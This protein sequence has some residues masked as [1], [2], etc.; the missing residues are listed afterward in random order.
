MRKWGLV[1]LLILSVFFVGCLSPKLSIL[2]DPIEIE[3]GQE[4]LELGLKV[5]PS[6]F[7]RKYHLDTITISIIENIEGGEEFLAPRTIVVNRYFLVAPI[8]AIPVPLDPISLGDF[9]NLEGELYEQLRGREFLLKVVLDGTK[10]STA[11]AT[12]T[13]K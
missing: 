9:K 8:G 10:L 12:V 7:S 13:F 1:G 11:E 5:K 3:Q 4:Y 2:L 6:G